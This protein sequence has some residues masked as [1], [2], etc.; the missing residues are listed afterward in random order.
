VF[1][2]VITLGKSINRA[3]RTFVAA[4]ATCSHVVC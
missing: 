1:L 3:F 2:V 4:L